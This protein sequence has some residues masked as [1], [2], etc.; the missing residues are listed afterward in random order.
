[1]FVTN[2]RSGELSVIDPKSR[3]VVATVAL[4]KRPRGMNL[5]PDGRWLYTANGPSNDVSVVD[6]RSLDVVDTVPVGA[7]PWGT[8]AHDA[9][10]QAPAP[11]L[12]ADERTGERTAP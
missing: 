9:S 10:A 6:A 12:D 7:S 3:T 8:L 2:E 1:V 11:P 5:S 4:G